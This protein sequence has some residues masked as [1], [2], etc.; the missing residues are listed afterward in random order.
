MSH[1]NHGSDLAMGTRRR[2]H[3]DALVRSARTTHKM[4]STLPALD[5]LEARLVEVENDKV[6][7][8]TRDPQRQAGG[9]LRRGRLQDDLVV[10]FAGGGRG[11]CATTAWRYSTI[12]RRW[13]YRR[14]P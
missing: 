2:R 6:G 8:R 4:F 10:P 11:I 14:S 5:E 3:A 12:F 13:R 7:P 9:L 1:D